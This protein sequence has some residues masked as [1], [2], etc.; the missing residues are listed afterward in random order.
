MSVK[1]VLESCHSPT[2]NEM[3]VFE[4]TSTF[5]FKARLD[6]YKEVGGLLSK[7]SVTVRGKEVATNVYKTHIFSSVSTHN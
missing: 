4:A 2:E 6:V 5:A 7:V 3:K 1:T